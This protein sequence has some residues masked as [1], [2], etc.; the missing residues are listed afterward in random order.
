MALVAA[1]L[2]SCSDDNEQATPDPTPETGVTEVTVDGLKA[3]A[4]IWNK[5]TLK[6]N[7]TS[8]AGIEKI[9]IKIDSDV[10]ATLTSA[11]FEFELN[12]QTLDDGDHILS[13]TA[14]DKDGNQKT[15]E[16][17]FTV[18][19]TLAY[20]NVPD[21]FL[22]DGARGFIFLSDSLGQTIAAKEYH[23]G[24]SLVLTNSTYTQERFT[25]TQAYVDSDGY[26]YLYTYTDVPRGR[27]TLIV[28][29]N[30]RVRPEHEADLTFVNSEEA[31]RYELQT[32]SSTYMAYDGLSTASVGYVG[33]DSKLFFGYAPSDTDPMTHYLYF[34]SIVGQY[35]TIDFATAI[36]M[37]TEPLDISTFDEAGYELM[38]I[39]GRDVYYIDHL[40]HQQGT[41]RYSYPGDAFSDYLVYTILEKGGK[42]YRNL[43]EGAPSLVTT[44]S[45]IQVAFNN[46]TFS[47]AITGDADYCIYNLDQWK[48]FWSL[49]TRP[50]NQDVTLPEVPALLSD[51]YIDDFTEADIDVAAVDVINQNNYEDFILFFSEFPG[52]ALEASNWYF[53]SH[54][55]YYKLAS[56]EEGRSARA[57]RSHRTFA[58]PF[59]R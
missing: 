35:A 32:N 51:F 56:P 4:R 27:W 34:P 52:D 14:T 54:E 55:I 10:V 59:R 5:I 57:N 40:W 28:G 45:D 44:N 23:A 50:G 31:G 48:Q 43:T 8:E 11:P 19:N 26:L 29:Y 53:R 41:L 6:L 33:N 49:F 3:N 47:G 24:D 17:T 16:V 18:Q 22:Q 12:P 30:D 21:D 1:I 36:P 9:E 7:A 38:S 37:T 46:K 58:R 15:T 42:T 25:L 13:V 20:I 2:I 39:S